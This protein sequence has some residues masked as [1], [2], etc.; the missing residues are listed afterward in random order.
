[1]VDIAHQ[2]HDD[3]YR[4]VAD[5]AKLFAELDSRAT[6]AKTL[7]MA[8][9]RIVAVKTKIGANPLIDSAK[10]A[11]MG[12]HEMRLVDSSQSYQSLLKS[13]MDHKCYEV[14]WRE[15][16]GLDGRPWLA[17]DEDASEEKKAGFK[18]MLVNFDEYIDGATR[19]NQAAYAYKRHQDAIKGVEGVKATAGCPE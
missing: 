10:I 8:V 13:Y 1:M 18:G 11:L 15:Q 19:K 9:N 6:L 5:P 7:G 12:T 14:D 17:I 2:L 16:S 4:A 3:G